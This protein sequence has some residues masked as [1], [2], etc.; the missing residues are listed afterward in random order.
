MIH[1]L[2]PKSYPKILFQNAT[3]DFAVMQRDLHTVCQCNVKDRKKKKR[4][5]CM[6][7][8][9]CIFLRV[10]QKISCSIVMIQ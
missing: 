10:L 4:E 5:L 3:S 2:F 6:Q 9:E 8:C 1:S 7:P